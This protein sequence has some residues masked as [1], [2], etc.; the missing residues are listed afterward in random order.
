MFDKDW[1]AKHAVP[2]SGAYGLN[3]P[4]FNPKSDRVMD[5]SWNDCG[6]W[7][8]AHTAPAKVLAELTKRW[9]QTLADGGDVWVKEGG[10]SDITAAVVDRIHKQ[11][12]DVDTTKRIHVVQHSNWN[13]QKTTPAALAYTKKNT[14]YIRI[15]DANAYLNRLGGDKAFV[16]AATNH[17]VFGP[18]WKAAFVYYKPS[19]RLDFSD[20]GELYRILG[21]DEIGID[22]FRE[23]FLASGKQQK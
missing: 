23:R 9:S 19:Q 11:M 21:L 5:V 6:G 13:E 8:A 1:I 7:L 10:Q 16:Q 20:T 22:A 2:V 12:P 18:A 14:D 15:K 3:A 4:T 17:P